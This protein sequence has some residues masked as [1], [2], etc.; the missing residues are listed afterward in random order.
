[1]GD[2]ALIELASVGEAVQAAIECQRATAEHEAG[3]PPNERIVFRIG[4]NLGDIVIE[5]DGDILGDGVNTPRG[6][7]S[8]PTPAVFASARR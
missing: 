5:P 6:W 3:R 4:I 8:S 2:G 7:S 1:M